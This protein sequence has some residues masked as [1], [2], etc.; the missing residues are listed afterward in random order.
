MLD[1]DA[2]M[3]KI[4]SMSEEE[5]KEIMYAALDASGIEY[6]KGNNCVIFNGLYGSYKD[7][8]EDNKVYLA[9]KCVR[10]GE[11][12]F[13]KYTHT[14]EYD[15]GYSK[16][17]KFESLPEGWI[18]SAELNGLLCPDCAEEFQRVK[19]VFMNKN[20]IEEAVDESAE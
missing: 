12:V 5:L 11:T 18:K 20:I 3:N 9:R 2:L 8:I 7:D 1:Y 14:E 15:G 17:A 6:K 4:N 19:D 16:E 10:C 13:L